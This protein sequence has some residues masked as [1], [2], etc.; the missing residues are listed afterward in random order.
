MLPLAKYVILSTIAGLAL[1]ASLPPSSNYILSI[2]SILVL[3]AILELNKMDRVRKLLLT[4]IFFFT[5]FYVSAFWTSKTA[6]SIFGYTVSGLVYGQI[7]LIF[8]VTVSTIAMCL[9]F[10]I[11]ILLPMQKNCFLQS[12]LFGSAWV[13]GEFIR[14]ELPYGMPISFIGYALS[15]DI[16]LIQVAKHV[17][18]FGIG[19]LIAL[20]SHLMLRT[21]ANLPLLILI[22]LIMLGYGFY[23]VRSAGIV[24]R[25]VKVRLVNT[26]VPQRVLENP[27][28]R[29]YVLY[30]HLKA[31]DFKNN[32]DIDLFIWPESILRFHTDRPKYW[33]RIKDLMLDH[34]ML[35]TGGYSSELEVGEYKYHNSFFSLDKSKSL[36]SRY[37]K[38]KLLFLGE[39]ITGRKNL[40]V[41]LRP[42][43]GVNNFSYGKKPSSIILK[44]GLNVFPILCSEGHFPQVINSNQ[45]DQD[46]LIMLGNEAWVAD[47]RAI[48]MT[49]AA[50]K[51]RAIESGLTTILVSN[52]GYLAVLDKSGRELMSSKDS[53][54]FTLDVTVPVTFPKN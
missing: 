16:Y 39:H 50:A 24:D 43:L 46:L 27:D 44:N 32:P 49:L 2:L 51:Y 36:P 9:S 6:T 47:T 34:Q 53:N 37:D 1:A 5:Y 48:D 26:S 7:F 15:S 22:P 41:E 45:R 8:I 10:L 3:A 38:K 54:F 19:F 33:A 18:V 13:V 28:R 35:I 14:T 11:Y 12:I 30:S 40:P 20:F 52:A 42:Y 21:Q 4:A 23:S 17:T 31:S 29:E 25:S